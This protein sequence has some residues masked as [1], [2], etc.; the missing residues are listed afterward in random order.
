LRKLLA[1]LSK[2]SFSPA[3]DLTSES[4]DLF[5]LE[6]DAQ[7]ESG[8]KIRL[9]VKILSTERAIKVDRHKE[10]TKAERKTRDFKRLGRNLFYL[11]KREFEEFRVCEFCCKSLEN[12]ADAEAHIHTHG[13]I[14]Y[15]LIC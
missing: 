13:N 8:R 10:C 9:S 3:R 4:D 14:L 5:F 6:S 1:Q 12:E 2:G 15:G 7:E 11:N